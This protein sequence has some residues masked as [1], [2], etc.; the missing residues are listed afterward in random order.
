MG[1]PPNPRL[2]REVALESTRL[3]LRDGAYQGRAPILAGPDRP[4]PSTGRSGNGEVTIGCRPPC[5]PC[6][7]RFGG[8]LDESR[9]IV[10][11]I[12]RVC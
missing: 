10:A 9:E 4:R 3:D 11:L 5:A 8:R 7:I 12:S 2:F 1:G 6:S